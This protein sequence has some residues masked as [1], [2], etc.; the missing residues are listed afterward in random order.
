MGK[1]CGVALVE[2]IGEPLDET[3]RHGIEDELTIVH[4]HRNVRLV[5]NGGSVCMYV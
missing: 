4:R 5:F 1:I 2:D 3:R